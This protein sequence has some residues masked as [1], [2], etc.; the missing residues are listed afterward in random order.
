MINVFTTYNDLWIYNDRL[1]YLILMRRFNFTVG[2]FWLLH[3]LTEWFSIHDSVVYRPLALVRR[4]LWRVNGIIY[5]SPLAVFF[6]KSIP[7]I[8]QACTTVLYGN[9]SRGEWTTN[10]IH[11][12]GTLPTLNHKTSRSNNSYQSN[13]SI[14]N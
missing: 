2:T 14:E 7:Y 11:A 4:K 12:R 8:T 1:W 5:H 9:E 13:V 3:L 10:T 6:T